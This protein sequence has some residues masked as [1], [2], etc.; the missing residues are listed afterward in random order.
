MNHPGKRIIGLLLGLLIGVCPPAHSDVSLPRL[1][2]DGLVLQRDT[3]NRIWGWADEGETVAVKL[4]GQE[5]GSA[6]AEDGEWLVLLDAM[7]AG[8]PHRLEVSANNQIEINDIYFGE[9]WIASG[10]SNMQLSMDRVRDKYADEIAAA[11]NPLIRMFTV[12]REYNFEQPLGFYNAML[13]P[14][15]NLSLK[16]VIW[17]QG[18]SNTD[19]PE[20]YANLFP[21][22]IRDWRKQ[23]SR[24]TK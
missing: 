1:L 14:L 11:D 16:G 5:M 12:P 15:L 23:R 22:M 6:V 7:P 13:A 18:E 21:A 3:P 9:L 19:R 4:D 24:M 10:Q 17:Y 20:E 8:G 2:G